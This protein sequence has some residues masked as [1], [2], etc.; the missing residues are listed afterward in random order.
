MT[1]RQFVSTLILGSI[2]GVAHS[3]GFYTGSAL[4]QQAV[5]TGATTGT[6]LV[7]ING[8]VGS[9]PPACATQTN[10]FAMSV[11]TDVGKAQIAVVMSALARG[12]TVWIQ[13]SGVCDIS[14]DTES[15]LWIYTN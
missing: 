1:Y 15:A 13:G 5:S 4:Y 9:T 10:R 11:T 2:C 3:L 12:A 14:P 8:S 7:Y 6:F